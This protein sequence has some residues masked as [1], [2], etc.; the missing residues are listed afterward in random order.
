MQ[1]R[2]ITASL[3]AA[4]QPSNDTSTDYLAPLAQ[5]ASTA[6][7]P[8]AK[9]KAKGRRKSSLRS[10]GKPA[11][12]TP[13]VCLGLAVQLQCLSGVSLTG[14]LG[15]LTRIADSGRHLGATDGGAASLQQ[16]EAHGACWTVADQAAAILDL[17]HPAALL[18]R[19]CWTAMWL[20]SSA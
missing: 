6:S 1:L 11:A 7:S 16:P 2:T 13:Q 18:D 15:P 4:A 3:Q 5:L 9:G 17:V 20:L 8:K 10:T 14:V 12:A 19:N